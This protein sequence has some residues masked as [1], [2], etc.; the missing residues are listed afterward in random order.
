MFAARM[1]RHH[2]VDMERD[3]TFSTHGLS[4]NVGALLEERR[5][6][7]SPIHPEMGHDEWIMQW[8]CKSISFVCSRDKAVRVPHHWVLWSMFTVAPVGSTRGG[9]VYVPSL[10]TATAQLD[11]AIFITSV[12]GAG[13]TRRQETT[14]VR[15]Q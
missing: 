11:I 10:F 15:C 1:F 13:T 6:E 2:V 3:S 14:A 9:V 12:V 8:I 4:V 5:M 7:L